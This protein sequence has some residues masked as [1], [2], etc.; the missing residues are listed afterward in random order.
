VIRENVEAV[1]AEEAPA[2]T[3]DEKKP[4]D[5]P[6]TEVDEKAKEGAEKEEE[7]KEAEEDKVYLWNLVSSY[8]FT[9]CLLVVW[10]VHVVLVTRA[11]VAI[12]LNWTCLVCHVL[13]AW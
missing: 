7:E 1:N 3:E 11:M 12:M 9:F 2:V 8:S 6:P 10:H 5:A 13:Q 4:E